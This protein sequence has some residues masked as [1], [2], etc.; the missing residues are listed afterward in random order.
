MLAALSRLLIDSDPPASQALLQQA[1]AIGESI[2]DA[3]NMGANL[4]NYGIALLQRGR[5]AE[6][7]PYLERARA[8]FAARNIQELLPQTDALIAQARG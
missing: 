7:L 5:N 6:A 1:L 4:G 3:Y 8:L 2:N